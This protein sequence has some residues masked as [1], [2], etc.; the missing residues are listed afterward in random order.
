M[1]VSFRKI[2]FFCSIVF[3]VLYSFLALT[4]PGGVNSPD[5]TANTV[6][7]QQIAQGSYLRYAL[8]FEYG[9]LSEFI[10][11]R[12]TYVVGEMIVPVGFWGL[13]V[14]YGMLA[15]FFGV[16]IITFLTPLL[17]VISAWCWYALIS[18]VWN[19][20]VS[21][22]STLLFLMHPSVWYYS[23]RG[24]LPNMPMV[25]LLII[26]SF[27]LICQ[28]LY[29]RYKKRYFDD[30]LGAFALVFA[31]LMRPNEAPWILLSGLI[32]LF[33]Y[34]K[35]VSWKRV[36]VWI[37]VALLGALLFVHV[38]Q[39]IF[40]ASA[41][42]HVVSTSVNAPHWLTYLFPFGIA[43]KDILKSGYHYFFLLFLGYTVPALLGMIM[44]LKNWKSVSKGIQIYTVVFICSSL[45]LFTYYASAPDLLYSLKTIGVSYPRYWLPIFVMSLPFLGYFLQYVAKKMSSERFKSLAFFAILVI[46]FGYSAHIVFGGVDGIA[47]TKQSILHMQAVKE[48]VLRTTDDRAVIV[49][50]R[51]DKFFWPERQVM[52]RFFDPD[53]GQAIA[54]LLKK[55]FPVYY[56]TDDLDE[57]RRSNVN[58]Y[59]A[60]YNV[61]IDFTADFGPHELY[62]FSFLD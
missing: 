10:H 43:L 55:E 25:S 5:E 49:T 44:V 22:I 40:G 39:A 30:V 54:D 4:V 28:P 46:L 59:I 48:E 42:A 23:T 14:L 8:P 57:G 2:L 52:V 33:A 31:F 35:E 3:F 1:I 16:S 60:E 26:G 18:R 38:N 12:S 24:L 13:P 29:A 34:K 37:L 32:L 56:F 15:S 61:H 9:V 20:S 11:P 45:Y 47:A 41:G 17:T 51:E 50:D 27:F 19:T 36:G 62:Q 53:I 7:I 6:F 21:R 58:E